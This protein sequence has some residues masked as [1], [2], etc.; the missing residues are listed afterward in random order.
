[1][2]YLSLAEVLQLHLLVIEQS[3]GAGGVRDLGALESAVAQPQ[4]TFAS[5]DLY[6]TLAEKAASLGYSLVRNHPFVDGNKRV[7]HAAMETFVLLNGYEIAASVDDQEQLMLGLASGS[8]SREKLLRWL[9]QHL[10]PHQSTPD[11]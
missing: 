4:L 10:V 9:E 1:M 11:R 8:V 5:H 3:G 2:R 7:S 6:F